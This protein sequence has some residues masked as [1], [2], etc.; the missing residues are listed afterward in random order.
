M[1]RTKHTAKQPIRSPRVQLARVVIETD[2]SSQDMSGGKKKKGKRKEAPQ[3]PE[4]TETP[5]KRSAAQ[6]ADRKRKS[7]QKQERRRDFSDSTPPLSPE[8]SP[9]ARALPENFP[10][11][12]PPRSPGGVDFDHDQESVASDQS[13]L[14][15]KKKSRE[16]YRLT[17]TG[18]WVRKTVP[19]PQQPDKDVA[20]PA[21]RKKTT[22]QEP[23][24]EG[25]TSAACGRRHTPRAAN[26]PRR[27][28][29]ATVT[30]PEDLDP[31]DP[32]AADFVTAPVKQVAK[33]ST[34]KAAAASKGKGKRRAV[35]SD[36]EEGSTTEDEQPP[37]NQPQRPANQPQVVPRTWQVVDD[38]RPD[39]RKVENQCR[40]KRG[41][42]LN[43]KGR[44]LQP[45]QRRRP[46]QT[47]LHQVRMYQR[48]TELLIRKLPFQRLVREITQDTR[49]DPQGNLPAEPLR[50]T[51]DAI[52]ALQEGSEAYL[53]GLFEDAH[54][55]AL[56]AR[57]VTV[58]V[59]DMALSRNIRGET[60]I[61][62]S[63]AAR[64]KLRKGRISYEKPK[65]DKEDKKSDKKSS[66]KKKR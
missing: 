63:A 28:P 66:K 61:T 53:T 20:P 16:G 34:A 15:K 48:R 9:A 14:H 24:K 6:K 23:A 65:T 46:G 57:R 21:K 37:A 12:R 18:L 36:E 25:E 29:A 45:G 10:G 1:A 56:H 44:P 55:A 43:Y 13:A 54:L 26:P 35:E 8:T 19:A 52:G 31:E 51:P 64:T 58:Q 3:E 17:G 59:E 2:S 7:Q 32:H 41:P 40:G 60:P 27:Q 11:H 30:R 38:S 33:K 62:C 4:A 39:P 5:S 22:P 49:R 47:A 50:W 42:T